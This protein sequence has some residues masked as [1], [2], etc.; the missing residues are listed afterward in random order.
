MRP[1][2][3]GHQQ[4]HQYHGRVALRRQKENTFG[5]GYEQIGDR[6]FGHAAFLGVVVDRIVVQ[7]RA[8]NG[9]IDQSGSEEVS[10]G[11]LIPRR[12]EVKVAQQAGNGLHRVMERGQAQHAPRPAVRQANLQLVFPYDGVVRVQPGLLE[13]RR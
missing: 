7:G 5:N 8:A 11:C 4:P 12:H 10:Q 13:Q 3:A 2:D 6:L 9:V 1:F